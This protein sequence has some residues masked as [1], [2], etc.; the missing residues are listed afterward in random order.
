MSGEKKLSVLSRGFSDLRFSIGR[1]DRDEIN[2]LVTQTRGSFSSPR[3]RARYFNQDNLLWVKREIRHLAPAEPGVAQYTAYDFGASLAAE[4]G[5]GRGLFLFRAEVW[6]P[7]RK[8]PQGP[9]DTRLV[10]ITDLGVLVKRNRD[11]SQT[12]SCN[13][14]PR[15]LPVRRRNGPGP[16]QERCRRRRRADR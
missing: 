11:G 4:S 8:R 16:G 1:I 7:E 10:L 15:A 13:P 9:N 12:S 2:H 5:A 14:S 3:F 6:D